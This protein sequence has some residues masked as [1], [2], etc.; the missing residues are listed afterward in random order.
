MAKFTELAQA[1]KD[2]INSMITTDMSEE[3]ISK[4]TGLVSKVDGLAESHKATE[5]EAI[6]VKEKY[7]S[8]VKGYGTSKLP[9]DEEAQPRSLE[10]IAEAMASKK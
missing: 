2:E 6:S 1:L 5:D 9:Q 3:Q 4:M 7:I 8:L 10:E